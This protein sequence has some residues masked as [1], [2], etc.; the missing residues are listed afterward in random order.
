MLASMGLRNEGLFVGL[1]VLLGRPSRQESS[2]PVV[3]C[4]GHAR[5]VYGVRK[6][7]KKKYT[8]LYDKH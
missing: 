5:T 2:R 4:L 7:E 1:E 6:I 8:L 3:F